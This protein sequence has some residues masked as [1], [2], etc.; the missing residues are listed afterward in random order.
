MSGCGGGA[1][2]R[3]TKTL[4]TLDPSQSQIACNAAG[5]THDAK[6]VGQVT[7]AESGLRG[8]PFGRF[9]PVDP[10]LGQPRAVGGD[11]DERGAEIGVPELEIVNRG[12]AVLLVEGEL[13]WLGRVGAALTGDEHPLRLLPDTD[14]SD[15]R[16]A[17]PCSRIQVL[18]HH[19]DIAVG[20]LR[21]ALPECG[22]PRRR[23][24]SIGGTVT[25]EDHSSRM[26]C[27]KTN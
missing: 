11:I 3:W 8:L 22:W 9:V 25:G 17:L 19:I 15:P 26:T 23:E 21:P 13:Q 18:A 14:R 27:R 2:H 5:S 16:T 6:S 24:R 12:A 1:S 4:I 7:E 20:G 10:D